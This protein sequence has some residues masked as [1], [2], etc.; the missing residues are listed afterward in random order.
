MPLFSIIKH[1]YNYFVPAEGSDEPTPRPTRRSNRVWNPDDELVVTAKCFDSLRGSCAEHKRRRY[2]DLSK[3]K[4]IDDAMKLSIQP[5]RTALHRT[6]CASDLSYDTQIGYVRVIHVETTPT[7][8][9]PYST[10]E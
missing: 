10:D 5:T 8:E 1:A 7:E 9:T 3:C 2:E 6:Y 4:T